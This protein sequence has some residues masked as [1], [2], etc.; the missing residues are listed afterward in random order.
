MEIPE[1][2]PIDAPEADYLYVQPSRIPH[3]GMGLFTAISL[4]RGDVIAV[5]LGEQLTD[6][7]AERRSDAGEDAY[8]VTLLDG[9]TLDSM[10]TDCFAKYANDVEGP[11][12]SR[13]RNNAVITLDEEDRPCI[14]A[15][16][17][18]KAGGEVFV[19]YGKAYWKK[20]MGQ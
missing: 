15:T 9:G 2:T 4:H 20:R 13:L 19:G 8:F 12:N 3:A 10:H 1:P 11:G 16:R 5:F 14:V 17:S 18:I 7:E 6:V